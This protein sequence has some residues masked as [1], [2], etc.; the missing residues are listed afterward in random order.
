MSQIRAV[1]D[2]HQSPRSLSSNDSS[3]P[4]NPS[5]HPTLRP[6]LLRLSTRSDSSPPSAHPTLS[7]QERKRSCMVVNTGK[8]FIDAHIHV[9]QN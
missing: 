3:K 1:T 4:S 5:P 9:A 8:L 2:S 6:P 7:E